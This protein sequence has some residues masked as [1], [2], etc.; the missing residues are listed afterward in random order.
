MVKEVIGKAEFESLTGQKGKLVVVS[1][2]PVDVE[3]GS[4]SDW[5]STATIIQ[6]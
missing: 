1:F 4:N 5:R 2:H 6:V 3:L